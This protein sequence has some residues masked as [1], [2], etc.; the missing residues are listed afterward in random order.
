MQ[1]VILKPSVVN[2]GERRNEYPDNLYIITCMSYFNLLLNPWVILGSAA[3][4]VLMA[5]LYPSLVE[6]LELFSTLYLKLLQ[7][8]VLPV[9]MTAIISGLGRLFISGAAQNYIAKIL[10]FIVFNLVLASA[11][12]VQVGFIGGVGKDLGYQVETVLGKTITKAETDPNW[13]A[14]ETPK[15]AMGLAGFV[16]AMIPNN[17]FY[18]LTNGENLAVV[19][20][21]IVIG[22]CMGSLRSGSGSKALDVIDVFYETFLEAINWAM[23]LLP[24]GLFCIFSTQVNNVGIEIFKAMSSLVLCIYLGS[25]ILIGVFSLIVCL[26]SGNN[27]IKSVLNFRQPFIVAFGTASGFATIPSALSVLQNKFTVNRNVSDLILPL[28]VTINPPGSVL[29]FALTG[30]FITQIYDVTLTINNLFVIIIGAILAG[31]SSSSAPGIVGLSMIS[32]MLEPL[33]VPVEVAVIL[34]I[35]I[36]PIVDPILTVVNVH[37]NCAMA[38]MVDKSE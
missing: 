31:I 17:I 21:S 13:T 2:L 16:R 30:I 7:M 14:H 4:G 6:N 10:A 37:A 19:F 20:F 11:V 33:G 9:L 24:F 12:G 5:I 15:E 27:Y 8:L 3:S 34:L 1:K 25:F 22:I 35:A 36:D 29:Y 28:G 32:I 38:L 23:Y 18:S 26:K